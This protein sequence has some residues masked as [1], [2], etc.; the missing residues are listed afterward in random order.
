MLAIFEQ[1]MVT[2][3]IAVY[4]LAELVWFLLMFVLVSVGLCHG[5]DL[6]IGNAGMGRINT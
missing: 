1:I 4:I 5:D 3:V 2:V 6:G